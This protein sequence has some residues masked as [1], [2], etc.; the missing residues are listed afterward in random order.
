MWTIEPFDS[1]DVEAIAHLQPEGWSDIRS[2]FHYYVRA[3]ACRPVK[4]CR[5]RIIV[6]LGCAIHQGATGWLAHI[7]VAAD[8]RR[9]GL[10]TLITQSLMDTLRDWN[11]PTQLL[12]AT[13]DGEP[14][15]RNLGFE[16]TGHY[17]FMTGPRT[18]P[19]SWNRVLIRKGQASDLPS[20]LELDHQATG[21]DR[22]QM[23]CSS[24]TT[25]WIA[26]QEGTVTGFCLPD[27]GEGP[28]IA[29]DADSGKALLH[30]KHA[31]SVI[32]AVFPESNVAARHFFEA[33]GFRVER[34]AARMVFGGSDP[35]RP[36]MIFARIGGHVG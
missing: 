3:S 8:A 23:L 31:T 20:I 14:L 30:S 29:T 1:R 25:G 15:Y 19:E 11:C 28:V 10:G 34:K 13:A 16:V 7:I 32:K 36:S 26:E 5:G 4:V 27:L 21:E 9:R 22:R 17:L 2:S 33:S 6:G 35:V 18:R 24:P 12:I